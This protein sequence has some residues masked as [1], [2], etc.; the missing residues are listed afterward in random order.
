MLSATAQLD[1]HAE[2]G[3]LDGQGQ[4]VTVWGKGCYVSHVY[5]CFDSR[6][7]DG[8]E[9]GW[10]LFFT[11][12]PQE[13]GRTAGA[14]GAFV[15]PQ[16]REYA[17]RGITVG[18]LSPLKSSTPAAAWLRLGAAVAPAAQRPLPRQLAQ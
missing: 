8:R 3:R 4:F 14:K 5:D 18:R 6:G 11:L 17:Y 10:Q 2:Y 7:T 9:P 13:M 1:A 15:A 16:S 12:A